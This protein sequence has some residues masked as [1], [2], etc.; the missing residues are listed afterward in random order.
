VFLGQ[1]CLLLSFTLVMSSYWWPLP[2]SLHLAEPV[3]PDGL[4][5]ESLLVVSIGPALFP[6]LTAVCTLPIYS[7]PPIFPVS[8]LP[9]PVPFL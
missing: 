3:L 4:C 2:Y 5:S 6:A 7:C 9:S 8:G 1:L